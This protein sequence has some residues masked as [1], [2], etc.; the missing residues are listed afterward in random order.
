MG[1][2]SA[3]SGAPKP[4]GQECGADGECSSAHCAGGTCCDKACTGLCQKCSATGLCEMPSDDSACGAITC[5]A[6]SICRDYAS[7]ISTNRCKAVG[8]C[9][10]AADCAYIDAPATTACG[11]VRGMSELAPAMCDGSGACRARTVKCGGD[12]DC[13][14]DQAW[15]CGGGNGLTC[16][17]EDCGGTHKQGPYLCDEKRDCAA[18]Y[19]CCLQ[20]T[21]GGP[22]AICL[23]PALCTNDGTSTRWS[24]CNP[25]TSPT[26]CDSGTSCQPAVAG[27]IGW[28]VCR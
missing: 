10:T 27:P 18:G 2:G 12:A 20:S 8:Q 13:V 19:V 3:G 7:A 6:D 14:L 23:T 4:L 17:F 24:A 16:Q 11:S 15:C 5:P 28:Y 21:P 9:K 26:E 22:S 25:A 1:G